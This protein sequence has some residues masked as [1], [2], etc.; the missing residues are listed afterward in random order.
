MWLG[1]VSLLTPNRTAKK[2]QKQKCLERLESLSV[3]I[4]KDLYSDNNSGE[5]LIRLRRRPGYP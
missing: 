5:V 4:R 3:D 1:R 2:V